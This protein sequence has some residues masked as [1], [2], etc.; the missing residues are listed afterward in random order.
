MCAPVVY[1]FGSVLLNLRDG[2]IESSP[3]WQNGTCRQSLFIRVDGTM[4]SV[5][6]GRFYQGRLNMVKLHYMS[7]TERGCS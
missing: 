1:H 4:L 2:K 6:V 5:D 7:G 3:I